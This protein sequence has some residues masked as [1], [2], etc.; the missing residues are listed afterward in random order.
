MKLLSWTAACM[1]ALAAPAA[2]AQSLRPGLWEIERTTRSTSGDE[3]RRAAAAQERVGRL[4]PEQ[5]RMVE[6]RMA[7]NGMQMGSAGPGSLSGKVCITPE[8]AQHT[9]TAEELLP[10]CQTTSQSRSASGVKLAFTCSNP[11]RTGET[12]IIITG[13]E[14]YTTRTVTHTQVGGKPDTVT[15]TGSGHWVKADCGDVLPPV[16]QKPR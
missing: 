15:K 3:E 4:P 13:R 5:R 8:M 10:S 12:E 9:E 2:I 16:G 6:E 11:P 1:F 14:A 7:R